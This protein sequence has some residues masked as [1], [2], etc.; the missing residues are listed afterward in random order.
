MQAFTNT[1][2]TYV[3]SNPGDLSS[4]PLLS[5]LPCWVHYHAYGYGS[6]HPDWTQK[7]SLSVYAP[8]SPQYYVPAL[9][10]WATLFIR[11]PVCVDVVFCDSYIS[12]HGVRSP[13]VDC[14]GG[15]LEEIKFFCWNALFSLVLFN[16]MGMHSIPKRNLVILSHYMHKFMEIF[17]FHNTG[18]VF[19]TFQHF[20]L[21]EYIF[22]HLEFSVFRSSAGRCL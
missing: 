18:L 6:S 11:F 12:F 19:F 4:H 20:S 16:D 17:T 22:D 2:V 9:S 14:D 3:Q 21:L 15:Q 10:W 8:S 1:T 7:H 5:H 13:C